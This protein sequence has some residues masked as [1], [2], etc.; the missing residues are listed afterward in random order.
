MAVP[1]PTRS[2]DGSRDIRPD[3]SECL[4][5]VRMRFVWVVEGDL[6]FGCLEWQERGLIVNSVRGFGNLPMA[7]ALG[8]VDKGGS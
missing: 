6:F 1:I 3:D 2:S 5:G 4:D 8:T 7:S